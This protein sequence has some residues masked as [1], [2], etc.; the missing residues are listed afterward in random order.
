[1]LAEAC[2]PPLKPFLL[3]HDS[4]PTPPFPSLPS[5]QHENQ[6]CDVFLSVFMG[7]GTPGEN[8]LSVARPLK[9]CNSGLWQVKKWR[10]M[11]SPSPGHRTAAAEK[12]QE[13]TKEG[14]ECWSLDSSEA[15]PVSFPTAWG[16][17]VFS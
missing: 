2:K 4:L 11:S 17:A 10:Q 13:G 7:R 6:I 14:R 12:W 8:H 1:M 15:T 9:P 5:Q 3:L 16:L